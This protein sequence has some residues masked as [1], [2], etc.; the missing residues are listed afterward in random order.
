AE[1]GDEAG[2]ADCELKATG[3]LRQ[4]RVAARV[5]QRV[6]DLLVFVEIDVKDCSLAFDRCC[7][8]RFIYPVMEHQAIDEAGQRIVV[9][10]VGNLLAR[11]SA[12][13]DV[14]DDD[15]DVAR[16]AVLA[17]HG[18][19]TLAPNGGTV[20]ANVAFLVAEGVYRA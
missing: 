4:K 12:L 19:S 13:G 16:L 6:V 17:H 20:S 10:E 15:E 18:H 5:T 11:A 7:S 1:S 9:G 2:I 3:D 14:L 8:G